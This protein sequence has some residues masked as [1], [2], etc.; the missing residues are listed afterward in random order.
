MRI[1]L[2]DVQAGFGGLNPSNRT[3]VEAD[4]LVEELRRNHIEGAL[5]RLCPE[6][7]DFDIVRSNRRLYEAA[8][9]HPELIPCPAV[10]PAKCGDLPPEEEQAVEAVQQGAAAVVIRP[11]ADYW[12]PEPWICGRLFAALG[13]KRLPVLCLER[14][15]ALPRVAS[16]AES[17]PDCPFIVAEVGYRSHRTL[18]PLLERFPNVYL[19]IGN[20]FSAHR[21]IEWYVS[22][23]GAERLLF[24]TG[25]PEAEAGAAVAQLLYADIP[26]AAKEAIGSGNFTRLRERIRR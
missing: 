17:H 22:R 11:A 9:V 15:V 16:L 23:I 25:L 19:S 13:Q 6:D 26:D 24:G 3:V 12:T 10:V 20:P 7:L 1:P 4:V 2:I 21:G 8:A 5:S 18:L 14:L